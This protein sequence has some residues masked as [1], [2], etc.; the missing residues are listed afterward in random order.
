MTKLNFKNTVSFLSSIRSSVYPL[1]S[2]GIHVNLE[3]CEISYEW[4]KAKYIANA[5]A[6]DTWGYG[7]P[8]ESALALALAYT[9]EDKNNHIEDCEIEAVNSF[10][11]V[12]ITRSLINKLNSKYI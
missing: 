1:K 9:E 2:L 6:Q 12:K 3:D 10:F 8:M 11:D 7:L 5:V 4:Q